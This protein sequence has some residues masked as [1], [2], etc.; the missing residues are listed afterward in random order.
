MDNRLPA[1]RRALTAGA[2]AA[3]TVHAHA[4]VGMAAGYGMAALEV[5][6]RA[7]MDAAAHGELASLGPSII[8]GL[9]T[10]FNAA[11]Q[12]LR[13]LLGRQAVR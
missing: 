6:L 8:A 1:L 11:A 3:V 13:R 9:E 5:R 10:D 7:I 4:M 2:P 12:A